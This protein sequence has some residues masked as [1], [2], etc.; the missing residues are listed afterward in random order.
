M[1]EHPQVINP[2]LKFFTLLDKRPHRLAVP[3]LGVAVQT[4]GPSPGVVGDLLRLASR[5]GQHIVGFST[6]TPQRLVRLA[7][8]V[9]NRLI[10]YLLR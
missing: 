3:F 8:G 4:L 1:L 9:G 2:S 10:G 7:A 6:G 5:L